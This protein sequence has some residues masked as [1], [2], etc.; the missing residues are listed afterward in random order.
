MFAAS[1]KETEILTKII[2][3]DIAR[4]RYYLKELRGE[5]RITP[6]SIKVLES[7]MARILGPPS[8]YLTLTKFLEWVTHILTIRELPPDLT[9]ESLVSHI[10]WALE[11]KRT[12]LNHLKP[13]FTTD[14]QQLPCW[15]YTIFKLGRYAVASMALLQ[16]ASEVPSLFNPML[17]Q[18][19]EA[20][21]RTKFAISEEEMPLTSVLRRLVSGREVHYLSRL[22]RV[23]SVG[24]P[25]TIY[26]YM[27]K[28]S[29]LTSTTSILIDYPHSASSV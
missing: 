18:L 26:L 28:C 10:Q 15:V 13:A 12:H 6:E 22:A 17:V 1:D 4:I 20:P 3:L 19:V 5:N 29:F 8:D 24:N 9:P 23:W 11:A 7:N 16:L 21:P 14:G 2:S 27:P 25:E